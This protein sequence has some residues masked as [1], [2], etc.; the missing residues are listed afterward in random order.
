MFSYKQCIVIR[1]DLKL[2][3]GKLAVQVAHAAIGAYERA[4]PKI[5]RAWKVEGQKKVVLEV[6]DLKELHELEKKAKRLGFPA[7]LITDAGLTE[8]PPDTVT[9]LGIGPAKSEELDRLTGD[10]PLL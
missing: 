1:S 2:S 5:R 6:G 10:L 3:T 4:E 9:A 8:I 7:A